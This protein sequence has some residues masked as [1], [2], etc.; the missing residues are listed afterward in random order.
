MR[1][2]RGGRRGR[3][4]EGEEKGGRA[5]GGKR[6]MVGGVGAAYAGKGGAGGDAK[7]RGQRF[8]PY[9]FI[10]LDATVLNKRKQRASRQKMEDTI[11]Q[12]RTHNRGKGKQS[13]ASQTA[14]GGS[15]R[16]FSHSKQH[17]RHKG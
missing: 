12:T 2:G 14:Q 1:R 16:T 3:G 11:G 9:A 5:E 10:P 8:D 7:R 17:K 15:N 13:G 4:D 6:R